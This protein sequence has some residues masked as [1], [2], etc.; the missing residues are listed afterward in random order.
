MV[1]VDILAITILV[2]ADIYP[3]YWFTTS[4]ITDRHSVCVCGLNYIGVYTLALVEEID[5]IG[6]TWNFVGPVDPKRGGLI[7]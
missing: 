3:I 2:I 7:H 1:I 5:S 4:V 6:D